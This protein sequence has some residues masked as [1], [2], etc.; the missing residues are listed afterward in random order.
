MKISFVLI[1][2]AIP[3]NTGPP[4]RAIKTIAYKNLSHANPLVISTA[5]PDGSHTVFMNQL[6]PTRRHS[7]ASLF[8][9]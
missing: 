2:P 3:E 1:K 8:W 4:A 6:P 9:E 7:S 5:E